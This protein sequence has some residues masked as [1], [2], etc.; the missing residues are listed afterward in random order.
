MNYNDILRDTNSSPAEKE[1]AF[2]YFIKQYQKEAKIFAYQRI[3][4]YVS[5][6]SEQDEKAKEMFQDASILLLQKIRNGELC[7]TDRT[8]EAWLNHLMI[9]LTN[10][11]RRKTAALPQKNSKANKDDTA[12]LQKRIIDIAAILEKEELSIKVFGTDN[13]IEQEHL[14]DD[15]RYKL[16]LLIK[17]VSSTC[18][19]YF[20]V[21]FAQDEDLFDWWKRTRGAGKNL[22]D[23]SV[24]KKV[25]STFDATT[26]NCKTKIRKLRDKYNIKFL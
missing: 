4:N 26:S 1:A 23:A 11:L 22:E 6:S 5:F 21:F 8:C 19:E 7:R 10:N 18:Q 14:R 3:K 13:K 24:L 25:R 12:P 9:G 16:D 20:A 15:L 2:V 17:E